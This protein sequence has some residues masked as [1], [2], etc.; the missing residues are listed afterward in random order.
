LHPGLMELALQA[1]IA[2]VQRA[3]RSGKFPVSYRWLRATAHRCLRPVVELPSPAEFAEGLR[4]ARAGG[5]HASLHAGTDSRALDPAKTG[6]WSLT[7][8]CHSATPV[9]PSRSAPGEPSPR[10]GTDAPATMQWVGKIYATGAI[11]GVALLVCTASTAA[12]VPR[13]CPRRSPGPNGGSVEL[14]QPLQLLAS[15]FSSAPLQPLQ[16]FQGSVPAGL[17]GRT[18]DR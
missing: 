3:V 13:V 8:C 1:E 18:A 12:I 9:A 14:V 10:Q 16:S 6:N 7:E 17:R 15:L 2:G 5:R 11:A 4:R